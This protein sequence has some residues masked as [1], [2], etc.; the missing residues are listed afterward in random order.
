MSSHK[1]FLN[2]LLC[3]FVMIRPK[4]RGFNEKAFDNIVIK[5]KNL[6]WRFFVFSYWLFFYLLTD[7]SIDPNKM[8]EK[9]L[10]RSCILYKIKD[11]MK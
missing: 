9:S 6:N 5:G 2:H 8:S 4:A 11:F 7:S 10:N 3:K 1:T